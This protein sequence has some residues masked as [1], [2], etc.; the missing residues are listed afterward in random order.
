DNTN[1][2]HELIAQ[3]QDETFDYKPFLVSREK[4]L[5]SRVNIAYTVRMCRHINGLHMEALKANCHKKMLFVKKPNK[6]D[7]YTQDCWFTKGSLVVCRKAFAGA[8][9]GTRWSI[10]KWDSAEVEDGKIELKNVKGDVVTVAKQRFSEFF[11]PAY[12]TTVHRAQGQTFK[13]PFVIHE[14]E[15]MTKKMLYTAISRSQHSKFIQ[16]SNEQVDRRVDMDKLRAALT[17]VQGCTFEE[18]FK[19]IEQLLR[20]SKNMWGLSW[21]DWQYDFDID[22]I[23]PKEK[24][25]SNHYTDLAPL[26]TE[27]NRSK[28]SRWADCLKNK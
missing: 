20:E 4:V 12:C 17:W 19:Y 23:K 22:H 14:V 7:K 26:R 25:G 1:K 21:A 28:Q 5:S 15:K 24:G 3:V 6:G 27:A 8:A 13:E 2:M 10:S 9:N 11:L 18:F 16:F